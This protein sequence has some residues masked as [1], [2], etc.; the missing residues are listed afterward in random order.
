MVTGRDRAHQWLVE[1][2]IRKTRLPSADDL[3]AY[4]ALLPYLRGGVI[5]HCGPVVTGRGPMD[6]RF[7]AAGPTTSAR[8]EPYQAE[9]IRH[10]HLKG[11]IGK[12]GM[13]D[14]TLV[15]LHELPAVYFHAVGGAA[16]LIASTVQRVL[17]VH[18]LEFG[19]PEAMWVIEVKDF[20]ATVTMDAHR[21]NLHQEIKDRSASALDGL[22]KR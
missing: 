1:T 13:S 19:A 11:V 18:K 2:I 21:R 3:A 14:R 10:F 8:E 17:S 5:Y 4:E 15:A 22:I 16:A 20:P 9:V 12:G 6:Y 7:T